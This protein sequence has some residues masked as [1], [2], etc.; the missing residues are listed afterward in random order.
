MSA[1]DIEERLKSKRKITHPRPGH[2]DLLGGIKYRFDDL[3][4]SLSVHQLVETTMRVAVR[5]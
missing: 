4:N 2:A 1:E 3:R 5:Q